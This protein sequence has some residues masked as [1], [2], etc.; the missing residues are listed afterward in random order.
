VDTTTRYYV[1]VKGE[2]GCIS[3]DSIVVNVDKNTPTNGYPVANAFTPNGDGHN[4]CFGIK[5]WGYIGNIEL[6]VFNRWGQRVFYSRSRDA[7][8]DG[9]YGGRPQP[10]GEYVYIIKANTLCGNVTRKG[11]LMLI[12]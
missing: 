11:N 7:C 4:D 6:S 12:R 2:N 1:D 9:N 8:W 3:K 10:A 5:Y